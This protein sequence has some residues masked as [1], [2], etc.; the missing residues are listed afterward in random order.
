[1]AYEKTLAIALITGSDPTKYGTL[2]AH[3]SNQY[4]MGRDE[5]SF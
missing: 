4:A 1:M 3:L 2:V 5:Y